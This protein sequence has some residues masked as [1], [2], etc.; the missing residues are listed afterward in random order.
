MLWSFLFAAAAGWLAPRAE[1]PLFAALERALGAPVALDATE[2]R[3]L[4]VL[5]LLALAAGI[6]ALIGAN[7][8]LFPAALGCAGGYFGARLY[9]FLH[10]PNGIDAVDEGARWDGR[11]REVRRPTGYGP[12]DEAVDPDDAT[13]RAVSARLAGGA[14][15]D[16]PTP[17]PVP[18]APETETRP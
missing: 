14:P 1:G 13:L 12:A 4:A 17:S 11:V 10:D 6:V 5:A 15:S 3:V 9:A 8:A 18:D 16:A 7:S 2:R